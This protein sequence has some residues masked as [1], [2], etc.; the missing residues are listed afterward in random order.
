LGVSEKLSKSIK[1]NFGDAG[2]GSL[3]MRLVKVV[4]SPFSEWDLK[5]CLERRKGNSDGRSEGNPNEVSK[6]FLG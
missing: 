1:G 6:S 5:S 3:G 2:S 4:D